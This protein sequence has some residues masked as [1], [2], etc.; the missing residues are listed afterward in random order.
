MLVYDTFRQQQLQSVK[1][2]L[3]KSLPQQNSSLFAPSSVYHNDINI[4]LGYIAN[5]LLRLN[6]TMD[7]RLPSAIRQKLADIKSIINI[8]LNLT[9]ASNS[10]K[11]NSSTE[12]KEEYITGQFDDSFQH[13]GKFKNFIYKNV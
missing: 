7:N 5:L 8:Q 1:D 13:A 2:T 12:H 4:D 6:R 10:I 3:N 9:S 11:S